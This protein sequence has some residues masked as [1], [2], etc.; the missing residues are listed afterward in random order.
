MYRFEEII[1]LPVNFV[2]H[3]QDSKKG[4]K[5]PELGAFGA[6]A[7]LALWASTAGRRS[8]PYALANKVGRPWTTFG[9]PLATFCHI[10]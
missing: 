8:S 6:P 7:A 9:T 4:P 10:W 5:G 2:F 3:A 1:P